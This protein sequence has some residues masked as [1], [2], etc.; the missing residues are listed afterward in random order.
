MHLFLMM[1][2]L[3]IK[4]VK[5]LYPKMYLLP[6]PL[7]C[8]SVTFRVV[9][10]EVQLMDRYLKMLNVTTLLFHLGSTTWQMQAFL[11]VIHSLYHTVVFAI[12][13]KSDL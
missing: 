7:T 6:V 5:S 3:D 12:T 13:S 10:R 8:N 1:L 11:H 9:R 2:F 4:T